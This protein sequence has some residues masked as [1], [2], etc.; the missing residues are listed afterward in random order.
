MANTVRILR[1]TTAGAVPASLVSGQI[2]INENDGRLYYRSAAGVVT[3]FSA[4][5]TSVVE[6]ATTASFPGTGS[7]AVLY[8]A[9]D[10]RRLYSWTGSVYAEVG[11]VSSYDS[12]WDL[13]LPPAPTGVSGTATSGQVALTWTAPTVL[14]QT[15]ITDYVVQYS[16]NGGSTWTTFSDGTS[17]SAS[18]TVTGL[19]NGT[20]YTFRVAAVNGVG[21]GAYSSA[22]A[23]VTPSGGV[24][25]SYLAIAGGGGG[26]GH[27]GG[28]GGGGGFLEGTATANAGVAYTITVGDGGAGGSFDGSNGTRG[29]NG[30]DS[31]FGTFA[32]AI[33]GG[34]GG[35]RYGSVIGPGKSG[36]SGGGGAQLQSPFQGT[37]VGGS[38]TAGQGNDGGSGVGGFGGGG[39]G[40]GG[41]GG[42][43]TVS[44][45]GAAGSGKVS[46]IT[47]SSVTYARGGAGGPDGSASSGYG[48]GGIGG[49]DEGAGTAGLK[50]VVI[51]RSPQAA[52][53]TTGS[54]SVTTVGTDTVYTFTNS[55]TI[56]F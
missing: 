3:Q 45:R 30:S 6:Y 12:R 44:A 26:G 54:P 35:A 29:T 15:P 46:S 18:A 32:T 1:S 20:A 27:L 13:F 36:G 8:L 55:G 21:T 51:I 34:G 7:S 49:N 24:V 38:G 33:G 31:V 41:V 4:G 5:A 14:S 9:T 56:T 11:A 40:A 48:A 47:G 19:T 39:G 42:N 28:G 10:T 37:A 22:S 50:G 2:A 16:S 23:A 17:A 43:A 53:S 52:A 25:I